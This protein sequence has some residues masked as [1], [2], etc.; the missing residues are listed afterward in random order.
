LGLSSIMNLNIELKRMVVPSD[1]TPDIVNDPGYCYTACYYGIEKKIK[2]AYLIGRYPT[3]GKIVAKGGLDTKIVYASQNPD[4]TYHIAESTGCGYVPQDLDIPRNAIVGSSSVT[5]R[6]RVLV[7]MMLVLVFGFSSIHWATMFLVVDY[8]AEVVYLSHDQLVTKFTKVARVFAIWFLL[9]AKGVSA[10]EHQ[11]RIYTFTG[12]TDPI[13]VDVLTLNAVFGSDMITPSKG[14]F[15]YISIGGVN[16]Y[17]LRP[18]LNG[19]TL[20]E[21]SKDDNFNA[22]ATLSCDNAEQFDIDIIGLRSGER[23]VPDGFEDFHRRVGK[24]LDYSNSE[25]NLCIR[26]D[27]LRYELLAYSNKN[28]PRYFETICPKLKARPNWLS[29]ARMVYSFDNKDEEPEELVST[30]SKNIGNVVSSTYDIVADDVTETAKLLVATHDVSVNAIRDITDK[31]KLIA[32]DVSQYSNRVFEKGR[33]IVSDTSVVL[34]KVTDVT[35]VTPLTIIDSGVELFQDGLEYIKAESLRSGVQI[36][37]ST[38]ASAMNRAKDLNLGL[39]DFGN[40]AGNMMKYVVDRTEQSALISGTILNNGLRIAE[41]IVLDTP[42]K[43]DI[44]EAIWSVKDHIKDFGSW[45]FTK[46]TDT[47]ILDTVGKS[48]DYAPHIAQKAGETI[49]GPIKGF[50]DGL[51]DI[52][53]DHGTV[54][55]YREAIFPGWNT[56]K[57]SA[58]WI[59]WT[60]SRF[61]TIFENPS[62]GLSAWT[63]IMETAVYAMACMVIGAGFYEFLKN[64]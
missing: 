32:G 9:V 43:E 16:E 54:K 39:S 6:D 59:Y 56:G 19:K 5:W 52:S 30:M 21:L 51:P 45:S 64:R 7:M 13:K 35:I 49:A 3:W 46:I 27:T 20:R 8:A 11:D 26:D 33:D 28:M 42:D 36:V 15:E 29:E 37:K 17:C 62:G 38:T 40:H 2:M 4:G 14:M 1:F 41:Q 50:Y 31:A 12:R 61:L 25:D 44:S 47:D 34:D 48:I 10:G 24:N 18:S 58:P 57:K 55:N 60:N 23:I 53:D 63:E 22:D